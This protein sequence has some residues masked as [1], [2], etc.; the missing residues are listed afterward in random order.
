MTTT[1]DNVNFAITY[2]AR[3]ESNDGKATIGGVFLIDL[4]VEQPTEGQKEKAV[5][6]LR[7]SLDTAY[8]MAPLIFTFEKGHFFDQPPAA[9][10]LLGM[11]RTINEYMIEDAKSAYVALNKEALNLNLLF[12]CNDTDVE[13]VKANPVA[14]DTID[15]GVSNNIAN[16][17]WPHS[18]EVRFIRV[19]TLIHSYKQIL[20]II[21]EYGLRLARGKF[22][23]V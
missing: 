15:F 23:F 12:N 6:Q 16:V 20:P 22:T 1:D 9:R 19:I 2:N 5:P 11:V 4:K 8:G 18:Y 3:T 13:N 17:L 21:N 14:S 7:L 10:M